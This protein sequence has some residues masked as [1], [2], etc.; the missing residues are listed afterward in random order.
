M[1]NHAAEAHLF[2]GLR[3]DVQ[4]VVVA[5]EAVEDGGFVVGGLFVDGVGLFALG[6]GEGLG[7]RPLGSAPVA[8]ADEEGAAD[9]AAVDLAC[10]RVHDVVLCLEHSAR[11]ALIVHTNDLAPGLKLAA[12]ARDGEGLVEDHF[13]LAV[14]DALVVELRDSGDLRA[15][16][17]LGGVEVDGLLRNALEGEDYGIGWEDCE[18][19]VEFLHSPLAGSPSHKYFLLGF[20]LRRGNAT[21]QQSRQYSQQRAG[22]RA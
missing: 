10:L 8:L 22:H 7:L 20:E 18:V 4:R 1:D 16:G 12:L 15:A 21:H 11:L 2:A 13:T 3:V 14:E 19:G 9:G 5:V 6:W 17:I